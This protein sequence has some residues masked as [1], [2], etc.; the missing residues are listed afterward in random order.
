MSGMLTN[1]GGGSKRAAGATIGSGDRVAFL[2]DSLTQ[3]G[4]DKPDGWVRQVVSGLASAGISVEAIPAGIG[5]HR[6]VDMSERLQ[7]DVLA[8]RP[9]VVLLSCGVNDVWHGEGG[10]PLPEYRAHI[11]EIVRRSQ[12]SGARV[13]ILTSTPIGE[14]P[15]NEVNRLLASYNGCLREL[16]DHAGC[17][18]ID[19]GG[20]FVAAL[21]AGPGT[22]HHLTDDGVHFNALGEGVMARAVLD[23]LG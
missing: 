10:V 1:L 11:A 13:V 19:T 16:A 7:R 22:G 15:D 8:H 5:G 9:D 3:D 23:G 20:A 18:L 21:T 4:W 12:A 6:S 14:E 17:L 2:G